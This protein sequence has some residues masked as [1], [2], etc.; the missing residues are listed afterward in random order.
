MTD[1]DIQVAI[2]RYEYFLTDRY[3]EPEPD[4]EEDLDCRYGDDWTRPD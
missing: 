2:D 1:A 3:H 4:C